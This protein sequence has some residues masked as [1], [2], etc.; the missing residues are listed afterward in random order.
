[1]E[2]INIDDIINYA[3]KRYKAATDPEERKVIGKALDELDLSIDNADMRED[4][5]RDYVGSDPYSW[6]VIPNFAELEERGD[7]EIAVEYNDRMV[8]TTFIIY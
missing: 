8:V 6:L 5:V 7:E 3:V 1:M 2:T 4:A